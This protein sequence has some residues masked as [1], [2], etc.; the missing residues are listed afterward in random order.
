MKIKE[1]LGLTQS[2]KDMTNTLSGSESMHED[3]ADTQM[4]QKL[5]RHLFPSAAFAEF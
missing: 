1:E 5:T 4:F 2:Q 3:R